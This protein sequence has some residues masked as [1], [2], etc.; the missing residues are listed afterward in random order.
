MFPLT[1]ETPMQYKTMVLEL[2]KQ[3]PELHD[4]LR[5]NRTLLPTMERLAVELKT[6]HQNWKGLLSQEKPGSDS[7]RIASEALEIALRDLQDSL[8]SESE[9]GSEALSLDE[10]MAFLRR[11]TPP[12]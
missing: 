12:E 6:R 10:A 7:G 4:Q 2:L 9:D 1:K 11:P 5:Q 3:R 8:P